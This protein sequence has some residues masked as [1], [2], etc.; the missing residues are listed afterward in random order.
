MTP[1]EFI[2]AMDKFCEK[3][4]KERGWHYLGHDN[5]RDFVVYKFKEGDGTI[6]LRC[7]NAHFQRSNKVVTAVRLIDTMEIQQAN[8]DVVQLEQDRML[9]ECRLKWNEIIA[10]GELRP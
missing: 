1:D 2:A 3:E 5:K 4:S 7:D 6:R 8:F 10:A 9:A